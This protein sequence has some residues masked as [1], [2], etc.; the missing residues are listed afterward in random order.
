MNEKIKQT[1]LL[2]GRRGSFR[3]STFLVDEFDAARFTSRLY[4]AGWNAM[5]SGAGLPMAMKN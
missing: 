4:R 1:A 5:S 3:K 2:A